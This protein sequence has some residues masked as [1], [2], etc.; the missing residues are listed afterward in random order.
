MG[1]TITIAG[2]KGGC[3]KS[4]FAV[5]IS[6]SLALFERRTLLVDCDPQASATAW[7]PDVE[8]SSKPDMAS[9]LSKRTRMEEVIRP[10]GLPYLDM[11]PSGIDLF[12]AARNLSGSTENQKI[13][14]V[15]LAQVADEYDY[16]LLDAPSSYE[17]LSI[18]SVA[19]SD[20]ILALMADR[21]EFHDEFGRLLKLVRYIRHTHQLSVK[22]AG[23]VFNRWP[24]NG[25]SIDEFVNKQL[26]D[27]IKDFVF[28]SFMPEYA[29][30]NPTGYRRMPAA[31]FDLKSFAARRYME[32]ARELMSIF[33]QER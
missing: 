6:T 7:M 15:L 32:I 4:V 9:L 8:P 25:V 2:Q 11:I 24:D 3:G 22:L 14:R 26:A 31:L 28:R 27:G 1:T 30:V 5:N 16:I 29:G 12:P 23:I 33:E 19:A 21:E 20:W 10:T 13:L 17:F 18:A